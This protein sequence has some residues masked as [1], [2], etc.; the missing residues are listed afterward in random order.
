MKKL[1]IFDLDGTLAE[2][3]SPITKKMSNV[4]KKLL[5]NYSVAIISG[6]AF[7]QFEKQFLNNL[8][9][10][11]NLLNKLY[12]FP[13]CATSFFKFKNKE[14]EE[15]YSE[16]LSIDDKQKILE[17]FKKTFNQ[18]GFIIPKKLLY[19]KIIEDRDT[20]I[21][22]SAL[23]QDAPVDLK[24]QW[25]P[26]HVKRLAMIEI[27]QNYLPE[28]EIRSGGSTSIDITKKGI[29]KAYGIFKIQ[30]LLKFSIGEMLFIGDAIFPG[31]NDFAV[32]STGVESISTS[33]PEH[34]I[35][36]ILDLLK[37]ESSLVNNK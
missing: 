13:T 37:L 33:G 21:T 17:A 14:W 10:P 28:F 6:G 22:F 1:I 16:K 26:T 7:P 29:D 34:T 11:K 24:K 3:K 8:S 12:L 20:Q 36:I 18:V 31:G 23:G 2:S 27:L 32:V 30:E 5:Q 4:L 15:I 35:E 9:I 25:D 19:G